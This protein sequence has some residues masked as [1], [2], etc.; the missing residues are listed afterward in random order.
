[1][2]QEFADKVYERIDFKLTRWTPGEY[3]SCAFRNCDLSECDLFATRFIECDFTGCNLSL[4]KL[5]NTSFQDIKFKD[6]KMLGLRF[7]Q[8]DKFGFAVGFENCLLDHCSF[9][10]VKLKKTLFKNCQI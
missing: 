2:E 9:Y 5:R 4:A 8:C 3:E 6:C 1:M 10:Q 7:E